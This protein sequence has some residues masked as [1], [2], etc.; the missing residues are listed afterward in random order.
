MSLA[1]AAERYR[2]P[3]RVLHWLVALALPFQIYLGWAA[4][5]ASTRETE[6]RLI[7]L[8]Y[9]VGVTL[10]A[11]MVL[12]IT[13]RM[14]VG[15][16][17][18][19]VG[20]PAWRNRMASLAHWAIYALLF[21]LPASGYVIWVW[22]EAPRD[23]FGLFDLPRLFTPPVE[24]ETWR[25]IAWH[26]HYWSGWTLIGLVFLHVGTAIWHEFVLRDGL[27]RKRIV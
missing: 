5:F 19:L 24:D 1:Q 13:W 9:Q 20:E 7:R 14:A 15:V 8:H 18:S 11:L 3:A 16:P 4:E 17:A 21:L 23:V 2:L 26:V 12:R 25:A 22:M 6:F 27:I 10:A